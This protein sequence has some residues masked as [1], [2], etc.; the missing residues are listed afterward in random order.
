MSQSLSF[1]TWRS[2]ENSHQLRLGFLISCR[3]GHFTPDIWK[4]HLSTTNAWAVFIIGL[5]GAYNSKYMCRFSLGCFSLIIPARQRL[6]SILELQTPPKDQLLLQWSYWSLVRREVRSCS[7]SLR[8]S[9]CI[10][11]PEETGGWGVLE[12]TWP[13][14]E[15][16]GITECVWDPQASCFHCTYQKHKLITVIFLHCLEEKLH[17]LP[18]ELYIS[19]YGLSYTS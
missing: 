4:Q 12:S 19:K 8:G 18:V 15:C 11:A 5:L 7:L 3:V 2:G 6:E 14:Q 16:R 17:N 9:W 1:I 13:E 10:I